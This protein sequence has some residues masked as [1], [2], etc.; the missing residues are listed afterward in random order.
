MK[1]VT[2][3]PMKARWT[4]EIARDFNSYHD[5]QSRPVK[6]SRNGSW[7]GDLVDPNLKRCKMFKSGDLVK[8]D[9]IE[10]KE[11]GV[12]LCQVEKPELPRWIIGQGGHTYMVW[13]PHS[14]KKKLEL[15]DIDL[16]L[17]CRGSGL[18]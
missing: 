3:K 12:V 14:E 9:F 10:G 13:C 16:E 6:P 8:I 1:A 17:V 4:A 18:V 7:L 2:K 5:P 11:N 15:R